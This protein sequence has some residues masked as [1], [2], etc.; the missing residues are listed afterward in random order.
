M[1]R[2]APGKAPDPALCRARAWQP[3]LK[4]AQP[5]S[6]IKPMQF[7]APTRG[8]LLGALASAA[9]AMILSGAAANAAVAPQYER[10]R[11]LD[12]VMSVISDAGRLLASTHQMVYY[13]E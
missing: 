8:I 11:Q 3:A 10:L 7:P 4:G 1:D 2:P 9:M 6:R 5:R 12:A 13:R